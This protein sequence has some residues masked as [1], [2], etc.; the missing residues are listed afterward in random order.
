M[1]V[2]HVRLAPTSK[3]EPHHSRIPKRHARRWAAPFE[4]GAR[5]QVAVFVTPK[6]FVRICAHAGKDL[7]NEVGGGL[8]GKWR[9]DACTGEQFVVV[10]NVLPARFTRKGSAFLTF[11]Q[12][13]LVTMNEELEARFPEKQLIGW[14]HTHPRMAVFLSH[15]D[16][17]LHRHFFPEPWQVALVVEPHASVGGFFIVQQDGTLDPQRY[18]GFYEL[19]DPNVR[20]SVVHWD[21]LRLIPHRKPGL[22]ESDEVEDV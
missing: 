10:E 6:T 4:D 14:Y 3:V 2:R 13:S 17:F 9:E 1:A 20:G 7:E 8:V 16:L 22:E 12:D 5:P 19:R 21:N 11:T 15:Y 18:F